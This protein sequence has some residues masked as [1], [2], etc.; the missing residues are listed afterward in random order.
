MKLAQYN[1]ISGN[2]IHECGEMI[3]FYITIAGSASFPADVQMREGRFTF[4][5]SFAE[6]HL[7]FKA[8]GSR[9]KFCPKCK[10]SLPKTVEGLKETRCNTPDPA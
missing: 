5:V 10:K 3:D 2:A 9:I 7:N 4:S 1:T 6:T 8:H